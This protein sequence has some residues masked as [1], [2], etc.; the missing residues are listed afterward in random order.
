M[1]KDIVQLDPKNNVMMT[2]MDTGDVLDVFVQ[3]TAPKPAKNMH[4]DGE[5]LVIAPRG[6]S[7]KR[8]RSIHK[9]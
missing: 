9:H 8:L 7:Q 3:M 5:G 6:Q 4:G 2:Q 1:V